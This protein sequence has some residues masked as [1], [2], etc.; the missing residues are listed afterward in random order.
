M[1]NFKKILKYF[2]LFIC[3][4]IL[5]FGLYTGLLVATG[6]LFT[7]FDTLLNC[8]FPALA[9]YSILFFPL[10]ILIMARLH[11]KKKK[12]WLIPIVFGL[13]IISLNALPLIA[14]IQKPINDGEAQFRDI[15]G[16]NYMAKIPTEL[17]SKFMDIPYNFW[18]MYNHHETYDC[19]ITENIPYLTIPEYNDT[20]YFD[21]YCPKSGNGPFPTIINIHGGGWVLGNKGFPENRPHATMYL[22]SQGY[23]IFDI[24]Y[25]LARFPNM[26]IGNIEVDSLLE[27]IQ[28]TLGRELTNGSYPVTDQIV[29]VMGNFTNFLVDN[30]DDYKINLSS[31]FITGNSAGGHL[32]ECFIGWNTTYRHIFPTENITI[33]GL[34]P[35][36]GISNFSGLMYMAEDPLLNQVDD[37]LA[38]M[39][40]FFGGD[41]S[42]TTFNK[43]ISPISMIDSSAPPIL[44]LHG[45]NDE[46]V[47][48]EQSRE[49]KAAY[50]MNATN[51]AILIEFPFTGHAFDYVFGSP[52]G[53]ISLYY[54]E[55]FLAATRYT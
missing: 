25:G 15:F 20:F 14:G 42:N 11:G 4:L 32:T 10:I 17:K 7:I 31:V 8:L 37:P 46:L 22:A 13:I 48:I 50:D 19:N 43:K 18:E 12:L 47:P 40:Q 27:M 52:G 49:L 45:T 54:I 24:Q 3:Y 30:A 51:P 33:K 1:I 44:L 9:C 2:I 5:L 36:Y 34:I 55:R 23:C 16:S 26:S 21:Y 38:I 29:H 28:N 6:K 35:F 39:T 53:Q 41:I